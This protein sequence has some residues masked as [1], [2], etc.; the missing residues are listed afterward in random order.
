MDGSIA[1]CRTVRVILEKLVQEQITLLQGISVIIFFTGGGFQYFFLKACRNKI[2]GKSL[3][4]QS[5][6]LKLRRSIFFVAINGYTQDFVIEI[7]KEERKYFFYVS[8]KL[9][10]VIRIRNSS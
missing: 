1:F 2:T 10:A 7:L 4:I 5:S 9:C 3:S 8:R 6:K